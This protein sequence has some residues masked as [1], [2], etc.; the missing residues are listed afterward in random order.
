MMY[1]K[2]AKLI[3]TYP[4]FHKRK[5]PFSPSIK[6]PGR[7]RERIDAIRALEGKLDGFL[8]SL[9]DYFDI[10]VDAYAANVH[11]STALEGN[12]LALEE[13]RRMTRNSFEG[14]SMMKPD[15]SR[16]E[17]INHLS[18]IVHPEA[19]ATPW[20]QEAI[21]KVHYLL[22]KNV[23]PDPIPGRY[24]TDPG[25]VYPT[26]NGTDV[27]FVGAGS[28]S[29][30][31]EMQSLL[32]WLNG[33][34]EA[35][36]P[37]VSAAVFFHEFASIHPFTEGNGRAGRTLFNIYLQTHGFPNARLCKIDYEITKD[38]SRDTYYTLLSWTDESGDY[39]ALLDFFLDAVLAAYEVAN[40]AF[41]SKRRHISALEENSIKVLF[42]A[43]NAKGGWFRVK[44]AVG[45]VGG[46]SE[47]TVS[48][49]LNGLCAKG[50]LEDEGLTRARRFRLPDPISNIKELVG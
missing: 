44:D 8:L 5:V 10:V 22:T 42:G 11:Y 28:E 30:P 9:R 49:T 41:D 12:P 7:F 17:I 18:A 31:D 34:G 33:A 21:R 1:E 14:I 16:Q 36:E 27:V 25:P 19:F 2:Y 45:W 35:I 13:V 20:S 24:R 48:K 50:L 23:E 32:D 38:A 29:V 39:S 6:L 4:V 43:R 26:E 47:R 15:A 46:A 37:L 3:P 40:A